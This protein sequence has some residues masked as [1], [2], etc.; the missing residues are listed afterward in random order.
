M[1]VSE[2]ISVTKVHTSTLLALRGRGWVSSFQKKRYTTLECP[3]ELEPGL[4]P[5][6]YDQHSLLW[7]PQLDVYNKNENKTQDMSDRTGYV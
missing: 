2:Q 3:L 1:Y 5:P 6:I 7:C 4:V